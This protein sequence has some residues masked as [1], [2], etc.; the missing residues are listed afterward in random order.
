MDKIWLKIRIE[1]RKNLGEKDMNGPLL[2]QSTKTT[3]NPDQTQNFQSNHNVGQNQVRYFN[4]AHRIQLPIPKLQISNFHGIL[5]KSANLIFLEK[6]CCKKWPKS[7][8]QETGLENRGRL[9]V[10]KD[11][12]MILND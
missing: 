8:N 2:E 4:L 5:N 12:K 7:P 10:L 11:T 9:K 6:Y 3:K 1:L